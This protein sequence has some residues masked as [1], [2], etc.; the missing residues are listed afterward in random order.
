MVRL[1]GDIDAAVR[2]DVTAVLDQAA[3]AASSGGG[4]LAVDLGDVTF[5]DSTGLGCIAACI[6]TLG[7]D[8]QLV[9]QNPPR[10]VRRLLELADLDYL[11][12]ADG[13]SPTI[14]T[15]PAGPGASA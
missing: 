10:S 3:R 5:M 15:I 1:V 2:D 8:G 13:G 9:L 14:P 4:V 7:P 6:T 11:C 12:A